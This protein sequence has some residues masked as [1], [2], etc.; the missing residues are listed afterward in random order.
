[1]TFI[2]YAQNYEDVRLWR[3]L[4]DVGEGCYLDIGAQDPIRDSVSK[5]FY[6]AGWRGAHVEALPTYAAAL[7]KDRPDEQVFEVAVG[8]EPGAIIF[9]EFPETG[10]STGI[11]DIARRH[12]EQGFTVTM[13]EVPVITLEEIFGQFGAETIHWMKLDVEGMEDAVLASW[14]DAQ[15]RPWVLVIE[16]VHPATRASMDEKWRDGV[17][18]RGYQEVAFDGLSRYFVAEEHAELA[19]ALALAPNIFDEF[20]VT[21]W[22]FSSGLVASEAQGG[23][24]ELERA[25]ADAQERSRVSDEQAQLSYRNAVYHSEQSALVQA[26]VDELETALARSE[27][28]LIALRRQLEEG[29]RRLL[30]EQQRLAEQQE[31][32]HQ[33]EARGRSLRAALAAELAEARR[34]RAEPTF[35]QRGGEEDRLQA[36][37]QQVRQLRDQLAAPGLSWPPTPPDS[38]PIG[39]APEQCI[40]EEAAAAAPYIGPIEPESMTLDDLLD[41][42]D[43]TF[44]RRAYQLLLHREADPVGLRHY[45]R[46]IRRGS[47]RI[48]V[49]AELAGSPEARGTGSSLP[50]L[51]QAI[52]RHRRREMLSL[53]PLRKRLFGALDEDAAG[54][55]G[56]IQDR[57]ERLS[58]A[59]P[60]MVPAPTPA[61]DSSPATAPAPAPLAPPEPA[62][63]DGKIVALDADGSVRAEQWPLIK[64]AIFRR[65]WQIGSSS[66]AVRG[67]GEELLWVVLVGDEGADIALGT[68]ASVRKVR[69]NAPFEVEVATVGPRLPRGGHSFPSLAEL[70]AAVPDGALVL[71]AGA[72]DEF[73]ARLPS[74]LLQE[75]AW[76][77][78]FIL[79]DQSFAYGERIRPLFFH[80]IDP[81]HLVYADYVDGRFAV[82]S[83]RLK[84]AVAGGAQSL[85]E[86]A[87][88]TLNALDSAPGRKL[89][90]QFPFLQNGSLTS[91]DLLKDRRRQVMQRL[92]AQAPP[93]RPEWQNSVSVIINT[94]DGGYLLDGLV[95][96]LLAMPQVREVVIVSNNTSGDYTI[97]LLDRLSEADRCTVLRYDQPFNF[98]VQCNLGASVASGSYLLFLNDDMTLIGEEWLDAL[99]AH[100][101]AEHDSVAGGMLLYPDQTI[102]HGGMFLGFNNVA[103]HTYRHCRSPHG[104]VA[105]ELVAPRQVSCLTGACLLMKVGLFQK[106]HGFD[107]QLATGL[108][109]VDL[110]LRA[111]RTGARLILDPRAILFHLESVS[112]VPTLIDPGVQ[113]RR[114]REYARFARRWDAELRPDPWHNANFDMGHE[115]VRSLR[116]AD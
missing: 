93:T 77:R 26:R 111:S 1:V 105:Y 103:G 70:A 82:S 53:E 6:E 40:V 96:Q 20:Q 115:T 110:C 10:M 83:A 32:H 68:L 109:D 80:G 97:A 25:L 84:A 114:E 100:A 104:S 23:T 22:H 64:S 2:S 3:A 55:L 27:G 92:A 94:K 79:T 12:S 85:Y 54:Q 72:S 36:V 42:H 87:Q 24:A 46:R 11:A 38:E 89:H 60:V 51:K 17:R 4:K 95:R 71:F 75:S 69:E 7:R 52:R 30:R 39:L 35:A 19:P 28:E 50:G 31:A 65:H 74:A 33:A 113:R 86:V 37:E 78:D 43:E 106:L 73:D 58:A 57:L 18:A 67:S 9:Y 107:E 99:L 76:R 15:Q 81:V 45:T 63:E 34:E 66:E 41:L 44:V 21:R 59:S 14:G 98:S 16:S 61:V 48:K 108:Q 29:E 49:L 88:A 56:A 91:L 47:T 13:R 5:A 102:Q 62:V 101:G 8:R 116:I 112:L 90:L